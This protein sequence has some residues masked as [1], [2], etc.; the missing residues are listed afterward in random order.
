MSAGMGDEVGTELTGILPEAP[1]QTAQTA[2]RVLEPQGDA[3]HRVS[4]GKYQATIPAPPAGKAVEFPE[5]ERVVR[6]LIVHWVYG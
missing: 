2:G 1:R 6:G 4:G 3:A 5:W